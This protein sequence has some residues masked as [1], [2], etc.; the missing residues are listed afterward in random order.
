MKH[1]SAPT[2]L[3]LTLTFTIPATWTP[4]QALAVYELL[5][6]LR[7]KIWT[8]YDLQLTQLIRE[9]RCPP[10]HDTDNVELGDPPF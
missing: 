5:D 1:R 7:E 10:A 2:G 6:E 3:P 8:H 9:H 4:E